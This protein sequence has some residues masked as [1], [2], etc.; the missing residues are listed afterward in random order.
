MCESTSQ[1]VNVESSKTLFVTRES[2][3]YSNVF[4]MLTDLFN[5]HLTLRM[6]GWD[7]LH[8]VPLRVVM[9]D[10]HPAGRLDGMWAGVAAAGGIAGLQEPWNTSGSAGEIQVAWEHS[11]VCWEFVALTALGADSRNQGTD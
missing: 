5:A 1:A 11:A 6:L 4:H 8:G 10:R 7:S 9:L 2:K 3:E